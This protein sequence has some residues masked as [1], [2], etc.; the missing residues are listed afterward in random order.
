MIKILIADDH[1][2]VRA[3]LKQ[4]ISEETDL[5]VEDEASSVDELFNKL[6]MKKFDILILDLN[7]P[8][9]SGFEAIKEIKNLYP[10]LPIL[11]LSMYDEEQYG[12]RCLSVGANGYLKKSCAPEEMVN[13]I[14]K[15]INGRKY[16]SQS[17]AEILANNIANQS[18]GDVIKLLSNREIEILK[19]IASGQSAEQISKELFISVPTVYTYR[20]RIL[21]KLNLKSN[22]DLT[23]FA[24]R[25]KLIEW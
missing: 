13:A 15:I 18:E 9:R 5:I 23:L 16:I 11:V 10:N 2:I 4:I 7:M 21:E 8:G 22:V 6:K 14:R 12:I 3:G 1:A 25:N 20:S 19:R 24:I 17:L